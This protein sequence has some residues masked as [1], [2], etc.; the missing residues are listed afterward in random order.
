MSLHFSDMTLISIPSEQEE[1]E[2]DICQAFGHIG[3]FLVILV[4]FISFQGKLI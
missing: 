3:N 1:S 2:N 4:I